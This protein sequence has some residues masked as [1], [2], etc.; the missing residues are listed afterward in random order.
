ICYMSS[1]HGGNSGNRGQCSQPCRDRYIKTPAGKDYPLNLKDNSAYFDLKE[2]YDAGID[3]LKIEGRIK[4]FEYV[5]TIVN[6]WKKQIHSFYNKNRMIQDNSELYKVFNRDFSNS[7][8]KGDINKDMFIDNPRSHSTKHISELNNYYSKDEMI[9][10]QTELYEEKEKL[11]IEIKN[12]IDQI[13]IA[14]IP[15]TI[16]ISGVSGTPLKVSVKTPDTSFDVL[17][18]VNLVDVGTEVLSYEMI[19]KR[20]K[21]IDDTEFFIKHMELYL[22]TDLYL[23]F[24]ELTSIKKRLLFILNGSKEIISPVTVPVLKKRNNENIKP[25]LS[26]LI[27]S[28]K[29]INLCSDTSADIYFQLPNSF[30]NEAGKVNDLFIKN[31]KLIPW[32]PS[33][34]IGE[35]Y[36]AAVE[37]LHQ[38]HPKLIVTNN[39]GIA[40]EANKNGIPWIAGPYLNIANSYSLLCLQEN[41][42]CIGS[43]L[44]NEISKQQLKSIKKPEDFK[45]FF[46]IYQPIVLMTS[47]QC[48]FHQVSGCEKNKIDDICIQQ[49][50]KSSTI[51]NLKKKSFFIVKTK[52]NYHS[53]YSATNLLNTDIVRDIPDL[54]SSFFIDLRDIK[55]ETKIEMDKAKLIKLF[56]NHLNGNFESTQQLKHIIHPSINTQYK[57]GI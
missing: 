50:K 36:I 37:F 10:G 34:L 20:L 29:D 30:K 11:R 38:L 5:Y 28:H 51:T 19:L 49:C 8:L 22:D 55:T 1:V 4:E 3:S 23:P 13:S 6:S 33:I 41:F 27:S 21:A 43:F 53:V 24:K 18:E 2:L 9:K 14:K 35:D 40:L 15:L 57:E 16:S 52:G 32:F 42:N 39:T 47:R 17:S 46:S 44:S 48:L 31:K 26:V 12:K 7:F 25:T 45:L 56:E 54:F